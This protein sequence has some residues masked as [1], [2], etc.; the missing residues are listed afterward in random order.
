MSAITTKIT[1]TGN[2]VAVRIPA[3]IAERYGFR[4]GT[5]V[6]LVEEMDGLRLAPL[7]PDL[8]RQLKIA[9]DVQSRN[10]AALR[11]LADR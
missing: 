7:N 9:A 10:A 1:M 11:V 8:L 6:H 3:A 5:E 4:S 2:S